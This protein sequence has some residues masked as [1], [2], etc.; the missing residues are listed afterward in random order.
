MKAK[1]LAE[2]LLKNPDFEVKVSVLTVDDEAIGFA[3]LDYEILDVTGLADIGYSSRV[4]IL[5]CN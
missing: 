4:I 1:D 3:A 2:L 5:D